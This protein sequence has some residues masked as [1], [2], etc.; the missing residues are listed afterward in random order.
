LTT[1]APTASAA[2]TPRPDLVHLSAELWRLVPPVDPDQPTHAPLP[3][4]GDAIPGTVFTTWLNQGSWDD[5]AASWPALDPSQRTTVSYALSGVTLPPGYVV[6]R[7]PPTDWLVAMLLVSRRADR[8]A[9][10]KLTGR[11]WTL[12]WTSTSGLLPVNLR[13]GPAGAWLD[14]V[15]AG[16]PTRDSLRRAALSSAVGLT[17]PFGIVWDMAQPLTRDTV[18]AVAGHPQATVDAL[19]EAARFT[20]L[21]PR[22]K[23]RLATSP[24]YPAAQVPA[25]YRHLGD[26]PNAQ[27]KPLLEAE[28]PVDRLV[29]LLEQRFRRYVARALAS[30]QRGSRIIASELTA[31]TRVLTAVF[32]GIDVTR[33]PDVRDAAMQSERPQARRAL[34]A[35]VNDP[36]VLATLATDPDAEVRATAARRVLDALSPTDPHHAG[37]RR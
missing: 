27:L 28:I 30:S 4:V 23:A 2:E 11:Q 8:L 18:D 12:A 20:P 21:S 25:L 1:L 13:T 32:D 15:V 6:R 35:T 14:Q 10:S 19:S 24:R 17:L 29:D 5:V 9:D 34:A 37:A 33:N 26:D 3:R 31:S 16:E 36:Q 7:T 22:A